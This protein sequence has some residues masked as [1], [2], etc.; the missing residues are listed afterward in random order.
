MIDCH[1]HLQDDSFARDIEEIMATL[2]EVGV[3]CLVV[4][5]TCP[6]DW[7]RVATLAKHYPEVVPF[8]GVHPWKVDECEPG[9]DKLLVSFLEEFPNAGIGEIGLDKWIRNH[10]IAKQKRFLNGQLEIAAQFQRPIAVHC[11]KAWGHLLDSLKASIFS[12]PFL[13]HSFS[14]PEEMIPEFVELGAFFSVSGY[15]FRSDKISKLKVF[16]QIAN[17]RILLESDAPDMPLP[18]ELVRYLHR[19]VN[20]PANIAAIYEIFSE[21]R[22]IPIGPLSDLI[23]ENFGSW[24]G[25]EVSSA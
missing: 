16:E 2:R 4:N 9:W 1:L 12:S 7:D 10:D 21:W 15:F 22:G 18:A 14:G 3:T 20:H 19:E 13:L 17:E 6:A 23:S 5:G 25:G 24:I 11:L 8:F